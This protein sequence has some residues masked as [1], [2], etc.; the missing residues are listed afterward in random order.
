M[1]NLMFWDSLGR[2]D[3][4]AIQ[5]DVEKKMSSKFRITL[6][7][8]EKILLRDWVGGYLALR[9]IG[10]CQSHPILP[11]QY[12]EHSSL[13]FEV[14]H[15]DNKVAFRACNG[16][17]LA[18]V[19]RN[20]HTI[21][22]AKHSAD[23]SCY[24]QPVIG[25]LISPSFEILSVTLSDP[26]NV[27]CYRCLL[28]KETYIN[29]S[30]IPQSHIFTMTWETQVAD[31][32][33]WNSLWGVGVATSHQFKIMDMTAIL[34]YSQDNERAVTVVRSI[35]ETCTKQVVVPPKMKATAH[36]VA[37]KRNATAMHFTAI[38]RKVMSNGHVI[39][40]HQRGA[41]SGLIYLDVHLE[42]TIE[43]QLGESC[44]AM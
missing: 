36:L 10:R 3:S 33:F 17:F 32:V 28:K 11:V 5:G 25:D 26:S 23:D 44:I 12:S 13:Q 21:E 42:I 2:D 38:I 7:P 20:F 14:F 19:Y 8:S 40:M 4:R 35:Y 9:P 30:E 24:F 41:W 43:E 29:R 15:R 37:N 22:A 1:D 39:N 34:E 6:L 31:R 18:R 16:L 27:N